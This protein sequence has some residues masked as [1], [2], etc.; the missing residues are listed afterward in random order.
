M[1]FP[2]PRMDLPDGGETD[3]G[4]VKD[5]GEDWE[6]FEKTPTIHVR[7]SRWRG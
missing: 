2:V 5:E 3:S 6:L 1:T 7:L 4:K